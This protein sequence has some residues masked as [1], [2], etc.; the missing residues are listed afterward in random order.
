M[1]P[2][3]LLIL[4]LVAVV[5]YLYQS[6]NLKGL[7]LGP[8]SPVSTVSGDWYEVHFTSPD[9]SGDPQL[10]GGMDSLVIAD[11]AQAKESVDVVSFE[12]TL[13]SITEALIAAHDR[14]V[15]VRMVL[16]DGNLSEE[17]MLRLTK[18]L[19]KAGIPIVWDQRAAFM[20]DKFVIIDRQVLWVGSWN[21]TVNDTYYNN[22]NAIRFILS[23][24]AA[25][26]TAEFE[27]MFVNKQFGP[28]SPVNTPYP[29]LQLSDGT[30]IK[31]YFSPE[32]NARAAL[33]AQ[34]R[35]AQN[36]IAFMAFSFTDDDVARVLLEKA[37]AGVV[38]R[39]VFETRNAEGTG[40]EYSV[41]KKGGLDIRLDGNPRTMHHKVFVID[42]KV[43]ITGSYN[44]TASAAEDNDENLLI[45][46]NPDI[47]RSY[48]G[49]FEKVYAAGGE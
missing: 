5:A 6:G 25:N 16:D 26:Y 4:V 9:P 31:T 19:Q 32:D 37:R 28:K 17:D 34:L 8:G 12:Y 46:T 27:E 7:G 24:L 38:V 10:T 33:L 14:G 43:T 45:I 44:F 49:E 20:H 47:A 36:E 29:V 41:L 39:G 21:L 48:A 42:G 22:N 1:S 23:D 15:Q 13:D 3:Y 11:I 18:Q 30:T 35:E 2:L 40:S